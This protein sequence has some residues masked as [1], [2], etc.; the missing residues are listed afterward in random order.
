M[1]TRKINV[2]N[3]LAEPI[4][5]LKG[6]GEETEHLLN[7]VGIYTIDDLLEYFPYRYD[8]NS[9]KDLEEV[10]HDERV[11]V[12]GKVHSEP[13][14][15]YFGK[16][17]SRLTFRLLVGRYLLTVICFNRPYFKNK[18]SLDSNCDRNREMG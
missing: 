4:S 1:G 14:L 6:V 10:K 5:N 15:T 8:D 18:L 7:D 17:R 13:S 2:K 11:T 16:K 3:R 12:E 9:L